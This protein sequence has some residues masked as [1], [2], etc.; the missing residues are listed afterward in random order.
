M[1]GRKRLTFSAQISGLLRSPR[2]PIFVKN[3]I[4]NLINHLTPDIG[5]HV[6]DQGVPVC[7]NSI[8]F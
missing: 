4:S 2:N 5:W 1:G 3:R 7:S 8:I 6:L